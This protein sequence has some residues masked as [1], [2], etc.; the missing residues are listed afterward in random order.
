MHYVLACYILYLIL[1]QVL[2]SC[3]LVHVYLPKKYCT[4]VRRWSCCNS[5]KCCYVPVCPLSCHSS[6]RLQWRSCRTASFIS[7][8]T[9]TWVLAVSQVK[10]L[11]SMANIKTLEYHSI[12]AFVHCHATCSILLYHMIKTIVKECSSCRDWVVLQNVAVPRTSTCINTA[13][14][15]IV[16]KER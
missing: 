14:C 12:S 3:V 10:F 9:I 11:L 6:G 8:K 5:L 4:V 13:M 16:V 1:V 2:L 15:F 7:N